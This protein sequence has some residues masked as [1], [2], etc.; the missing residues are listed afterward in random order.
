[1]RHLPQDAVPLLPARE[2]L[3]VQSEAVAGAVVEVV[4]EQ[5]LVEVPGVEGVA[6]E[7]EAAAVRLLRPRR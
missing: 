4:E 7:E 6:V 2:A 1:V 3:E 5:E